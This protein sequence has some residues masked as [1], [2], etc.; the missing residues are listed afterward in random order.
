MA[1]FTSRLKR[2]LGSSSQV[3]L[4][5]L[6]IGLTLF[7][8]NLSAFLSFLPRDYSEVFFDISIFSSILIIIIATYNLTKHK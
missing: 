1:S 2:G 6:G 7:L 3:N 8:M 4:V 5:F